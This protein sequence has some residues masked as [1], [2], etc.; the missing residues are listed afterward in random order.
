ML[1][2]DRLSVDLGK[3]AV[4]EDLGSIEWVVWVDLLL[5]DEPALAID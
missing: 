3:G 5:L 4:V 2:S 1:L